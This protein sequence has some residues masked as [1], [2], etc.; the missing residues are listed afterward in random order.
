[1]RIKLERE[2]E[3]DHQ[4]ERHNS[5]WMDHVARENV[6]AGLITWLKPRSV[7]DP[8][9]GDG[10]IVLLAN[11]IRPIGRMV[12]NDISVPS[13]DYLR[14]QVVGMEGVEVECASIEEAL[15]ARF[16]MPLGFDVVVLTEILEHM[17]DPD[18]ILK[19]ARDRAAYLVASSPEMRVGQS[20]AHNIEHYW[21][22]DGEGYRQMLVESG[23]TPFHKTHMG[24]P[25]F[26]YDFQVWVC[27]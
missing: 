9:C 6:T 10:G 14:R 12:L 24:F 27:K 19:L 16:E 13:T 4:Y 15:R 20:D 2:G 18:A 22:F 26:D 1:M 21:Q 8:A 25:G 11:H 5:E 3:V 23:W 17:E 7:I